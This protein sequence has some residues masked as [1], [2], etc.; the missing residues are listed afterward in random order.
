[1]YV[2]KLN[3]IRKKIIYKTK[4]PEADSSGDG[5]CRRQRKKSKIIQLIFSTKLCKIGISRR[6]QEGI[7]G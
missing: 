4:I 5:F 1:V 7:R 2:I 3:F 6:I